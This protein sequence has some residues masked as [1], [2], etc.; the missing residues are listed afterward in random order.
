MVAGAERERVHCALKSIYL[1]LILF[2]KHD[3]RSRARVIERLLG[4]RY[5]LLGLIRAKIKWNKISLLSLSTIS[6]SVFIISGKTLDERRTKHEKKESLAP[7]HCV[8]PQLFTCC[9]YHITP[10]FWH[11]ID[12]V[13]EIF[14]WTANR[15]HD[16]KKNWKED[17]WAQR[18]YVKSKTRTATINRN[19][20]RMN[21]TRAN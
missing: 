9:E 3:E 17:C 14:I 11:P 20:N 19:M 15:F 1:I 8:Y 13:C 5:V 12:D 2:S 21:E 6:L 4:F 7:S 16:I 10:L 18:K